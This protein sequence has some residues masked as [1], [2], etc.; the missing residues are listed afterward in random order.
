M[1][2]IW[3]V[4]LWGTLHEAKLEKVKKKEAKNLQTSWPCPIMPNHQSNYTFS[5]F[6]TDTNNLLYKQLQLNFPAD[7]YRSS[8][9]QTLLML[10]R[11]TSLT[12]RFPWICCNSLYVTWPGHHV[13]PNKKLVGCF[14][15]SPTL[16]TLSTSLFRCLAP[17][18]NRPMLPLPRGNVAQKPPPNLKQSDK[19]FTKSC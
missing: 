2:S 10:C 17:N 3:P 7:I 4:L 13:P 14:R 19:P 11:N 1:W 15:P 9:F 12:S 18:S 5:P 8:W 6:K 16:H